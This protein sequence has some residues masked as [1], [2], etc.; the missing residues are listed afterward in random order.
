MAGALR[1]LHDVLAQ[2][3]Q[4]LL[5]QQAR[6]A[7]MATHDMLTGLPNRTGFAAKV[8]QARARAR[9]SEAPF[10]VA[11]L[12]L[13]GF[14]AVNDEHGHAAGD[15]LLRAAGQR[16]RRRLRA[17]DTVA[18]LGGDELALLLLAPDCAGDAERRLAGIGAALAEPFR[19]DGGLEVRV[20]ASIG[21]TLFPDDDS[22]ADGLIRHADEAMYAV[23]R[24]GKGH[25]RRYDPRLLLVTDERRAQRER[26][27][28]AL[29]RRELELFF[30]PVAELRSG[31][32]VAAETL[33]RWRHPERGLL[34]PD[35]ALGPSRGSELAQRLG[36]WILAEAM[37]HL[38]RW[39]AVGHRL[40]LGVN[41][42]A[43]QLRSDALVGQV[44]AHLRE[45]RARF[46]S[47]RN[48]LQFPLQLEVVETEA[49]DDL[50]QVAAVL[51]ACRNAGARIALDDFGTGYSSLTHFRR[52][53]VDTIKIDRTFVAG[54][55]DSPEDRS[56]VEAI[57]ALARSMRR[58]VVAEGVETRAQREA[59]LALGCDLIQGYGL[60]PPMPAADLEAW[61]VAYDG[62]PLDI[63]HGEIGAPPR[64]WRRRRATA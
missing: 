45:W 51:G 13:D 49:L 15:H 63:G 59:L 19:L 42:S 7:H 34:P 44:R 16:L 31:R 47:A 27:R 29:E 3:E 22:V 30:Q 48:P 17:I 37:Q 6:L 9:R 60:A 62:G 46:G 5:A 32:V 23:K 8:D 21:Y 18:R 43:D 40:C 41:L 61:L 14:K 26:V 28:Q 20:G 39:H 24:S 52:L 36:E 33:L 55:Q 38:A 50:E 25:V 64:S 10:I 53:P 54:M 1:V 57:I 11:L 58:Q 4:S 2:R 56:I 12:D 35:Q